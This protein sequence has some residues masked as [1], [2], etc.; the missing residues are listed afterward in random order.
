MNLHE[1]LRT[2]GLQ[3]NEVRFFYMSS[4]EKPYEV[5]ITNSSPMGNC[6]IIRKEQEDGRKG[7]TLFV[8]MYSLWIKTPKRFIKIRELLRELDEVD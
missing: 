1:V 2:L 8:D 5:E 3:K 6:D 7:Y 4:F